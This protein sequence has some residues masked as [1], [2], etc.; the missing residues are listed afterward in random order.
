MDDDLK[1]QVSSCT[2][3]PDTNNK[4]HSQCSR[5]YNN[6]Q[7][8]VAFLT[9]SGA[10]R[11]SS[12]VQILLKLIPQNPKFPIGMLIVYMYII[13]YLR[14]LCNCDS[15]SACAQ[16]CVGIVKILILFIFP[17]F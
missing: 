10:R 13:F 3:S 14:A 7:A 17:K 2:M 9:E 11:Q 5:L 16:F 6:I 1:E 15:I 4:D 12:R 8:A